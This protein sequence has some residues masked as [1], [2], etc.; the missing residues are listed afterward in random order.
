MAESFAVLDEIAHAEGVEILI[1][2]LRPDICDTMNSVAET[3]SF[4]DECGL[5]NFG[6]LLDTDHVDLGQKDD[7]A[8]RAASLGF[9]HLADTFHVPL[10][11]GSIDF[12]S[13]FALLSELDYSGYCS[14][15]VF[16]D[17]DVGAMEF[18]S[19]MTAKISDYISR[20]K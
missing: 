1:E 17:R 4:I 20:A 18:L 6:W 10:G 11:R 16:G 8:K 2:P 7:I 12:P 14:V 15:E 3:A 19:E 9:V 13:Y 5:K